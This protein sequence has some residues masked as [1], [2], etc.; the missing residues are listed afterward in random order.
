MHLL[1]RSAASSESTRNFVHEHGSSETSGSESVNV[2]APL[3]WNMPPP[4]QPAL[5]TGDADIVPNDQ[6]LDAF[7]AVRLKSDVLL[8]CQAKVQDVSRVVSARGVNRRPSRMR[9]HLMIMSVL[10]DSLSK[11]KPLSRLMLTRNSQA[12]WRAKLGWHWGWR[13][14]S[15][16]PRLQVATLSF[17]LRAMKLVRTSEN[18]FACSGYQHRI[19]I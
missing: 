3:R 10:L 13:I 16:K 15:P 5:R 4:N 2:Q 18:P 8:A 12:R 1:Q 19:G 7:R 9:A 11:A 17:V 6:E 14:C